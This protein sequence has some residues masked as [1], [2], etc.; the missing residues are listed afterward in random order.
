MPVS[1]FP[2]LSIWCTTTKRYC[3]T[4]MHLW[5][6]TWSSCPVK[7]ETVITITV[8]EQIMATGYRTKIP[9]AAMSVYA[10][11]HIRHNWWPKFRK[12]WKRTTVMPTL[13]KQRL[14]ESWHR[15]SRKNSRHATSMQTETWSKR[16]RRPIC[17]P[18]N[19][20]YSRQ[21]KHVRKEWKH[22]SARLPATVTAWAQDSWVQPSWIRH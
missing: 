9:N 21:K 14:T 18:W 8:P 22:W 15:K 10:T 20:I 1:S 19:W 13:P 17:L 7:K 11:T 6:N 12:H 3:R 4:I 2:G 5:R 16:A